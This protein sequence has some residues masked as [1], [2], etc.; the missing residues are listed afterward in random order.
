MNLED[1]AVGLDIGTTKVVAIV[2]QK[3]TGGRIK[4]LGVGQAPSTG[5]LRGVV[6]NIAQTSDAIVQAIQ[7]AEGQAG[8]SISDLVV[9]IA[10]Q[11][12]RSI[13]HSDYITRDEPDEIIDQKDLH[14][15]INN[16]HKLVMIPGEEIIHVLPQVYKVDAETGIK[17][18]IGMFGSRLE[19]SFHIVVGK[20]NSISNIGSCVKRAGLK[21]SGL[22]LEPLASADACLS[23]DDKEAGVVLVDIGGG[24]TDV[25]I[26]KDGIIQHTAVIPF[27]GEI[28]TEDIKNALLIIRKQAELLKVKFGSAWPGENK[29]NEIVSIPGLRGQ[30]PKEISLKDLSKIIYSRVLEII[31]L[32][33]L[34]IKNY[35]F[36][37]R[38][39][40]LIAG[41]VLT[42]GGSQLKH[43]QQLVKYET[44]MDVR[45]GYPQERVEADQ[46][47]QLSNPMYSTAV[48]LALRA[49]ELKEKEKQIRLEAERIAENE[50]EHQEEIIQ[51]ITTPEDSK[52]DDVVDKAQVKEEFIFDEEKDV[53]T[54]YFDRWASKFM[55]F[56]QGDDEDER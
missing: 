41:I 6:T 15:L 45:I 31:D 51:P 49:T 27:G 16:V 39:K 38:S 52:I 42:G 37:D 54:S 3:S 30:E 1:I 46:A 2:A 28:I 4:V 35:G 12:I 24:T 47:S 20:I 50:V 10:G 8:I 13:Q 17:E 18:P 23:S 55:N 34:E 7:M 56:L 36:E 11:H 26:F 40:K 53:K 32:I 25:A 9:G 14:K 44:G 48:G 29:E 33:Y 5:V 19:A 22:T 21:V 43:I